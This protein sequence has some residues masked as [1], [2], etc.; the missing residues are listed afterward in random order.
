MSGTDGCAQRSV[1]SPPLPPGEGGKD[2]PALETPLQ[3]SRPLGTPPEALG[4]PARTPQ[5]SS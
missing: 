3:F 4:G 2:A 1:P 5:T